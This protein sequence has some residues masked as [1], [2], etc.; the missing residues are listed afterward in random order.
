M[1]PVKGGKLLVSKKMF[2]GGRAL[3]EAPF[4]HRK[5][6]DFGPESPSLE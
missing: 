3:R 4:V 1:K 5:P 2:D 6:H